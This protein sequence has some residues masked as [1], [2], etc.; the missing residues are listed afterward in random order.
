MDAFKSFI[1]NMEH[2]DEIE[3]SVLLKLGKGYLNSHN[4]FVI[5]TLEVCHDLDFLNTCLLDWYIVRLGL[6][7][8]GGNAGISSRNSMNF[9]ISED[10]IAS[11]VS[12]NSHQ[13]E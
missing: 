9:D 13:L 8:S 2:H 11:S 5:V 3:T 7:R 10:K 6:I 12:I 1:G 4:R